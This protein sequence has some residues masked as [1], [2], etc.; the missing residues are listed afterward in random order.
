MPAMTTLPAPPESA[1]QKDVALKKRLLFRSSYVFFV[2]LAG[3]FLFLTLKYRGMVAPVIGEKTL[4]RK[5]AWRIEGARLAL[6]RADRLG[7]LA[8]DKEGIEAVHSQAEAVAAS[9]EEVLEELPRDETVLTL[10]GRALELQ[11]NL[12][13][14]RDRYAEACS[15]VEAIS[16]YPDGVPV[17][18]STASTHRGLLS[19]REVLRRGLLAADPRKSDPELRQEA[20]RDL[21]RAMNGLIRDYHTS[22]ILLLALQLLDDKPADVID[23]AQREIDLNRLDPLPVFWRGV[24]RAWLLADR[25]ALEDFWG[26]IQ[27][28]PLAPEPHAWRG[29]VLERLG[30]RSAAIDALGDALARDTTFFEAWMIRARLLVAEGRPA[31]AAAHYASAATL[32]PDHPEAAR[33]HAEAALDAWIRGGRRESELLDRAVTSLT[34]LLGAKPELADAWAD[35]ARIHLARKSWDA[36]ESDAS[37]ALR[38]AAANR[39]ARRVRAEA[40]LGRG[41]AKGAVTDLEEAI[42][43]CDVAAELRDLRRLRAGALV[44]AGDPARAATELEALLAAD[45][46]DVTLALDRLDALAR[47]GQADR[48]L[49]ESEPL[50]GGSSAPRV[51]HFRAGLHFARKD[52]KA[53][54]EEATAAWE[55]DRSFIDPLM[56]RARCLAASGDKPNAL[57]DLDKALELAPGRKDEIEAVRK[58]L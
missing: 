19:V 15:R 43:A 55:A 29:R 54:V 26:A 20:M 56:L 4:Q 18:F 57:R 53:A 42:K 33:R 48:A 21:R 35:R 12:P 2:A 11:G 28:H 58:G 45:P 32:H 40:R 3:V 50:L 17:H 1:A 39:G 10:S 13:A 30:R 23:G 36:A 22:S 41:D 31:E 14:A 6:E 8:V 25:E 44:A 16:R 37:T 24:A 5:W 49:A 27:V 52:L 34:A 38:L 47:A 46:G 7:R 51:R 9:L